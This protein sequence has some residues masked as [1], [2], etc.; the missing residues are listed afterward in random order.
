MGFLQSKVKAIAAS[1]LNPAVAKNRYVRMGEGEVTMQSDRGINSDV[2]DEL[3][4]DEHVWAEKIS[5]KRNTSRRYVFAC[6]IFASLN[7][8]LL[9]YGQ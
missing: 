3:D 8:V 6:A 4:I 1:E 7:S 2:D 5:T 9:G